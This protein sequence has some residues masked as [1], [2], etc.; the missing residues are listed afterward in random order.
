MN[1]YG[2]V[3]LITYLPWV[4]NNNGNPWLYVGSTTKNL[5]FYFGSVGHKHYKDF[6]YKESRL[7]PQNF[8]KDVLCS[9]IVNDRKQ[10]LLLEKIIQ[11]QFDCVHDLRFFN[12]QYANEN[13][14]FGACVKGHKNPMFGV[15]RSAEWKETHSALMS[16]K[17]STDEHH[18]KMCAIQTETQ[19]RMEVKQKKSRGQKKAWEENS[20]MQNSKKGWFP[21]K[22]IQLADVTFLSI[23]KFRKWLAENNINGSYTWKN[24]D[25]W[26]IEDIILDDEILK[27]MLH[28]FKYK[29][30]Q[31]IECIKLW[32]MVGRNKQR[33]ITAISK[34]TKLPIHTCFGIHDRFFDKL[35]CIVNVYERLNNS[36]PLKERYKGLL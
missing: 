1:I 28:R 26:K 6:W 16:T 23:D 5:D 4:D 21:P 25:G 35:E 30:T 17:F 18:D 20:N 11:K 36:I 27:L 32:N 9:C 34:T 24:C 19:N 29:L 33:D 10:L 22:R 7:N 8:K 15:K 31:L 3:Y 2:V 12:K 13:G 14:A